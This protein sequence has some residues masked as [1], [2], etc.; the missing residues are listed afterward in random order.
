MSAWPSMEC[1]PT[2]ECKVQDNKTSPINV[3]VDDPVPASG[4]DMELK[5][6]YDGELKHINITFNKFLYMT[7]SDATP[8]TLQLGAVTY[9]LREV[10]IRFNPT[11]LQKA[12]EHVFTPITSNVSTAMEI[13]FFHVKD[14]AKG[15]FDNIKEPDGVVALS[16]MYEVPDK[17]EEGGKPPQPLPDKAS[18]TTLKAIAENINAAGQAKP[19][20]KLAS[21]VP[22]DPASFYTY[23]GSMTFPPCS[24]G[25]NWVII[26][27]IQQVSKDTL[28][29]LT[30]VAPTAGFATA[31]TDPTQEHDLKI[32]KRKTE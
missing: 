1:T 12:P 2:N 18:D 22:A 19:G 7:I 23:S 29:Q 13:Q 10:H 5:T 16:V 14:P 3:R 11:D 9:F 26:A 28:V 8:P 25:V 17:E 31:M 15:F 27:D 6:A 24:V 4:G 32:Y 21:L 20:L 30:T